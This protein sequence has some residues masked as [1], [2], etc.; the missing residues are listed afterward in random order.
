[1]KIVKNL[2]LQMEILLHI[3]RVLD[4]YP[5]YLHTKSDTITRHSVYVSI[6]TICVIRDIVSI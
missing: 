4:I 5:L 6:I 1:M 3:Y 2:K